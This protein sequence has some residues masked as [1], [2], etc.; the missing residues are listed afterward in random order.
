MSNT[1]VFCEIV[2][3]KALASKVYEDRMT[4]AFMNIRQA[5][6]GH[7]L[8]IPKDHV[9]TLD[10]LSPIQTA[11]LFQTVVRVMRA[12]RRSLDPEGVNIWQSNG[13]AA[14]Q[15]V[16]HVHVHIFPRRSG[17]GYLQF[18]RS[19]PPIVSKKERDDL[20]LIIRAALEEQV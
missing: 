1:C 4:L 16:P 15:E 2:E 13:A 14:M 11:G 8:V 18:Y 17:D 12:V 7:V 10:R 6:P 3:G 5:N 9:E 19:T 20:A